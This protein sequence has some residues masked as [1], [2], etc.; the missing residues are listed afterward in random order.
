MCDSVIAGIPGVRGGNGGPAGYGGR[1]G[2]KIIT[3]YQQTL[4]PFVCCCLLTAARLKSINNSFFEPAQS[5][6]H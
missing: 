4:A 1:S 5:S 6:L 3:A 2:K